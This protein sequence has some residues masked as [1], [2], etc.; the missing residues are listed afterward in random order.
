MAQYTV[1]SQSNEETVVAEYK[2]VTSRSDAYQSEAAL[3]REF[4]R[5][6]QEQ[7]YEYVSIHEEKDLMD[8]LR[9]Q[10]SLLNDYRFSDNEWRQFLTQYL[11]K[12]N[13]GIKEKTYNVQENHVFSLKRDNGETKN[14]K[15]LDK[16]NIHNNRLQVINQYEA[17]EGTF[18]N[19]YDVTILVNGLPLVH[20]ELK[21]R[22]VAIKEAFNQINRYQRDS[23]WSESGLYEY[24]QIFVISNGTHTKYYSNTTR[25][26]HVKEQNKVI[27]TEKTSNSFEFTSWWADARNKI[28]PDLI[29]FT[30][31]FFA[32]H[33]L[34]NILTKY[35]V[36]TAE[37]K[38]LVMRPYQIAATERI[39]N[40]IEIA[41][42]YKKYGSIE[43][44]GYIWHTT[45]SGKTLTS[46]KTARLAS[47]LDYI[48]KVLFVVDRKDLDYQ[49]MREYD[50]FEKGAANSNSS[51]AILKRQL[52][53]PNAHIIITTIQKLSIFIEQNKNHPIFDKKVV[54]IFDECHRSQF[55]DMHTAIVRNFK[56]Y[57]IFGFTGTPIFSV[58]ASSGANPHLKTTAQ[59]F[60]DQLHVYTVINAISDRNV[61]PFK[62]DYIKTM[63]EEDKIIDEQVRDIDREAAYNA[64]E[65]IALVTKYILEHFNQ[66]SYR[67]EKSY[68]HNII[69]NVHDVSRGKAEE[70]E[71]VRLTG[72]NSILATS[73]IDAAKLYYAE[74]KKQ[75]AEL[76]PAKQLKIAIIYSYGVNEDE[77]D[78]IIDEEN[79]ENTARLD[80]P[81]R[82]F[83]EAAIQDY[84][85]MFNTNFSTE[86]DGFQN[87]Y[88]ELSLRMKNKEIDLL[89]VVN[90]FLTGFDATTLNTL[91]V[92]KN[93]KM[94]GLMQAFSR[95]NRILNSI[96]TFGNI[97]CFRP[98]QKKV[99]EAIALF[100]D[101][102]AT[103][104]VLLKSFEDY[105]K[106]G[107]TDEKG[108]F[109]KP[110]VDLV[111]ELLEEYPL[112]EP[113]IE[114]EE[115][116]K[117]FIKLFGLI[118]RMKNLLSS[119]DDFAGREIITDIDFQDY[120][121]RYLDL[122]PRVTHNELRNV[123]EDI[124]FEIEL[125][126]QI[127][128][129]IDYILMLVKK[130][131]DSHCQDLQIKVAIERAIAASPELRSKRAL[132]QNFLSGINEADDIMAEWHAYIAEEK[133]KQ[134]KQ[135]IEE[136]NLKDAEAR[137]FVK[138]CFRDGYVKTNG[139]DLDKILPP[140]SRFGGSNARAEKKQRVLMKM[141]A[142][143]EMFY[144]IGE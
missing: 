60:G 48:D 27:R 41:T 58:N 34:L 88:R 143:F 144:G 14:I 96:K 111:N 93:L 123:N 6:L 117:E 24:V 64:P 116:Q 8:N 33:T 141:I 1:I 56:K 7:A 21:R 2:P 126:R 35:C 71:K 91:W 46:F 50:R 106:N 90:M 125:I 89:I 32:K 97:V 113:Q 107:Y 52:E 38:L 47:K 53:D 62:V 39:L 15:I 51:T 83:L 136:E 69:A 134:L 92:D 57:Y 129:N 82:D 36:F 99:D 43:A 13:A 132:I 101:R 61:L 94:H 112:S 140:M 67:N 37:E 68:N 87:Y 130:Y 16:Q 28:I 122:R 9:V 11:L 121:S 73:S 59:A 100:G 118:L 31:T 104:I 84:N 79:P 42:N 70:R 139:T 110:Y 29:D 72:F 18:K 20:V 98:L 80:Q 30:R 19:R 40:K 76:E 26:C 23:F 124:V 65:R 74:F 127:E 133:E 119:F 22:G 135:I 44:G 115:R 85:Q 77:I 128:V 102:D 86:G 4:I 63:E 12:A 54:L 10:L 142:F 138:N 66:K 95:T 75:M 114:S 49:T 78:G 55:G 45:G 131:H 25:D 105:Y 109:H 81:S 120:C 108:K 17:N 137:E 103:G 3:E 5:M